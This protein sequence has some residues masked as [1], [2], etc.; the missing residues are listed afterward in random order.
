MG[1]KKLAG[2][3]SLK[4]QPDDSFNLVVRADIVVRA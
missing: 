2:I 4:W 3:F 1:F